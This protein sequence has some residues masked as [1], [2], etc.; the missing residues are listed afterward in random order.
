MTGDDQSRAR[1]NNEENPEGS[2]AS[3]SITG[4]KAP[5]SADVT[6]ARE[7]HPT[8]VER[9]TPTRQRREPADGRED[10]GRLDPGARGNRLPGRT[11]AKVRFRG[12]A[13]LQFS[14]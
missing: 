5:I 13:T 7:H 6:K 12:A 1:G 9:D 11:V 4:S 8:S 2:P 14:A 10:A 3:R